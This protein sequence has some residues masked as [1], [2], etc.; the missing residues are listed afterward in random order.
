VGDETS[1]L[2][3]LDDIR[4]AAG[5]IRSLV[6]RTPVLEV[7]V[8]E[9]RLSLKCECFQPGGAFK[10]RGACNM[11]A[12]LSPE[13]KAAGVITYSSGNHGLAVALVAEAHAAPAVIVMPTTAPRVKV[14]AV[15]RHGAEVVFA[16]TT[17]TDRK[18]CAEDLV[19]ARGL[20][21]VPPF[22]HPWII[23]GQGTT[24]LEVLEQHSQVRSI[25]V[26]V[27]GGGQIAGAIIGSSRRRR[28]CGRCANDRVHCRGTSRRARQHCQHRRRVAHAAAG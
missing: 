6:R 10:I 21:M 5:R 9:T 14:E 18:L 12:Q 15:R 13:A 22:D 11:I 3:S 1:A 8:N 23:A 7:E 28:A 26:P 27:G 19:K 24:G 17:S 16:G 4:L 2:V 25:Y 20:T